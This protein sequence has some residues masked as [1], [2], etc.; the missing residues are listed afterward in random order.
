LIGEADSLVKATLE[1]LDTNFTEDAKQIQG[2]G[3]KIEARY[4]H[5]LYEMGEVLKGVLGFL[6]ILPS[7]PENSFFQIVEGILNFLQKEEWG[8]SGASYEIQVD[9]LVA[10]VRYLTSQM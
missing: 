5:Q 3:I 4:Q 2:V 7:N 6:V 9:V 10:C 8:T 1:T